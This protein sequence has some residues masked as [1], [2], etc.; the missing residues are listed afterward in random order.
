[1]S[2]KINNILRTNFE[3]ISSKCAE[4][5]ILELS[6]KFKFNNIEANKH[7]CEYMNMNINKKAVV[8]ENKQNK[9]VEKSFR[10]GYCDLFFNQIKN[11]ACEKI[12]NI[13]NIKTINGNTQSSERISIKLIQDILVDMNLNYTCAGS[14]QSKDFRNVY[15]NVKSLGINIEIKKTNE[16]IIYFNDTL[17]S[18]DVY[19][20]IFVIGKTYKDSNKNIPPQII[21]IN[22]YDLIKDDF[23]NLMEYKQDIEYLKNKW[24]RKKC[25]IKANS[26][27]HFSVYPR[28][29]FKTDI[30]YLLN[31]PQSFVLKEVEQHSQSE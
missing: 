12:K 31:S 14:Q 22:G 16:T 4:S 23:D 2:F 21:F 9:I 27:N 6:K 8:V 25:N 24:A 28:P 3:N 10:K 20:I 1:M 15:K 7:I 13:N 11:K 29:T 17:P 30:K 18:I 5:I 19:Y 26:F